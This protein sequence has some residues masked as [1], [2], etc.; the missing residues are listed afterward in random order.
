MTL[1]SRSVAKQHQKPR[2]HKLQQ[3][4]QTFQAQAL[5]A[6]RVCKRCQLGS[7]LVAKMTATRFSQKCDQAGGRAGLASRRTAWHKDFLHATN[8]PPNSSAQTLMWFLLLEAVRTISG[9][10][11]ARVLVLESLSKAQN[12]HIQQSCCTKFH[13]FLHFRALSGP[14]HL[15]CL[16]FIR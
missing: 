10:A 8:G 1:N 14:C 2:R 9:R 3:H 12:L 11:C 6:A 5:P 4:H 13:E 7:C 15:P 16:W